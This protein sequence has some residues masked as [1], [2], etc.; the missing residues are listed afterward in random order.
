MHQKSGWWTATG[1]TIINIFVVASIFH[2]AM[3]DLM[4]VLAIVAI[5]K[6][7]INLFHQAKLV[8]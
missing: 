1:Y 5:T 8:D 3:N 6:D 7:I 2:T 4:E